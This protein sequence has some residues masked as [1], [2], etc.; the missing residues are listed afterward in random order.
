MTCALEHILQCRPDDV[1]PHIIM[2]ALI[3]GLLVFMDRMSR[4]K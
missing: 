1:F 4:L 3:I 2:L